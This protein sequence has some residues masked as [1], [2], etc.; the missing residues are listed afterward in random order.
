MIIGTPSKNIL[1]PTSQKEQ[2]QLS[3]EKRWRE[4]KSDSERESGGERGR[5]RE[6]VKDKGKTRIILC[7][8]IKVYIYDIE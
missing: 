4:R 1:Q 7:K 2:K 5:E 3:E 6:R 8:S